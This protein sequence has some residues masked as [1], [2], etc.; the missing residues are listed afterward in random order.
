MKFALIM[1][2]VFATLFVPSISQAK[3]GCM[4]SLKWQR[5]EYTKAHV[6][7]TQSIQ[8]RSPASVH[9]NIPN[10]RNCSELVASAKALALA[11]QAHWNKLRLRPEGVKWIIRRQFQLAGRE[12]VLRAWQVA[13]CESNFRWNAYNGA[14]SG[15]WQ[16]NYVHNI[17]KHIMFSPELSTGWAWRASDHGR[18]F[19]PTWVC[20]SHY[21]IP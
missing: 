2:A 8:Q 17:P 9:W 20:A 15:V 1:A 16:L 11:E 19:S 12:A 3:T 13:S 21:G 4:Q 5:T 10:K 7:I 18:N 6:N 14:D